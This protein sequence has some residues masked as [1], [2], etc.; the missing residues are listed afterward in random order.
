M[1]VG[2]E[3]EPSGDELEAYEEEFPFAV[4]NAIMYKLSFAHSIWASVSIV[5]A[6]SNREATELSSFSNIW[7]AD[8]VAVIW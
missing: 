1:E 5:H 6:S 4:T 3:E 7:T 2:R 8:A